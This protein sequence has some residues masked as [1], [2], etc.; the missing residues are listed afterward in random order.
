P[1]PW[2][3]G[4]WVSEPSSEASHHGGCRA[5]RVGP[6]LEGPG[7]AE[8]DGLVGIEIG[9]GQ[10]V[11]GKDSDQLDGIAGLVGEGRVDLATLDVAK[12]RE[13]ALVG[14]DHVVWAWDDLPDRL[15]RACHWRNYQCNQNSRQKQNSVPHGPRL[16]GSP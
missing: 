9:Q 13:G 2:L 14:D 15:V 4:Y 8:R 6:K 3:S 1:D 5:V 10:R 16:H 12:Y 7:G 11:A